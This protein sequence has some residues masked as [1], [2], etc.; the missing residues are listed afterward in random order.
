MFSLRHLNK[1]SLIKRRQ[2]KSIASNNCSPMKNNISDP[3][4][5]S[6]L[7]DNFWITVFIKRKWFTDCG[8]SCKTKV[9]SISNKNYRFLIVYLEQ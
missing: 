8:L 9:K 6:Q 2:T 4:K 7:F 3:C 5:N 1:F